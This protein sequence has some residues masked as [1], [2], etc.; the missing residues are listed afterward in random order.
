MGGVCAS[1]CVCVCV[2]GRVGE[3][4][5]VVC[6]RPWIP[7]ARRFRVVCEGMRTTSVLDVKCTQYAKLFFLFLF[8]FLFSKSGS[9]EVS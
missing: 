1:V 5:W 4:K 9:A 3:V 6:D 2:L 8:L 7:R